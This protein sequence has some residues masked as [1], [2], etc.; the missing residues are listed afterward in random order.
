MN[1]QKKWADLDASH[2]F[3]FKSEKLEL[4]KGL[5]FNYISE[6]IIVSYR[7]NKST[8]KTG[9]LFEI[10]PA[11]IGH[12][13]KKFKEPLADR[14]GANCGDSV[15]ETYKKTFYNKDRYVLG[16]ICIKDHEWN[17][18]GKSLRQKS[19]NCVMCQYL[20]NKKRYETIQAG[21]KGRHNGIS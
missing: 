1:S 3:A 19:G 4:A 5:G 15:L 21:R 7:Q 10:S 14:G 8:R 17:N 12:I 11:G 6:A 2:N 18:T 13:L 20:N 9:D 16:P